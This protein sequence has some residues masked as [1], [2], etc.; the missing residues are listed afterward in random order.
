MTIA[1]QEI[2]LA[3]ARQLIDF[4][5]G[6][7]SQDFVWQE[8]LE[9]AVALHNILVHERVAYLAD[10]VGMGKTYVALGVA[11]LFR[12][13]NPGWRVLYITPRENIQRKWRKEILNFTAKNWQVTD[14]RVRSYQGTPAYGLTLCDNLLDLARQVMANPNRDFVLRMTSFSLPLSKTN[15]EQWRRKREELLDQIPWLDPAWFDL[16]G[17]EKKEQFKDNYA[18]AINVVL[19]HFD[20]VIIDEGHNLKHGLKV[21]QAVRNRL[22]AQVL[23]H[24]WFADQGFPGYG[25][26]FDRVLL[27]SAT[28][29][30]SD[31]RELWQ[32][33]NLFGYGDSW[34]ILSAT[35]SEDVTDQDKQAQT[36]RFLI[37]RLGSL[38]IGGQKQTKNLY[39]REWRNG[40]VLVHNQALPVADERQRLIVALVQKKVS[41]VL[42]SERFKNSFQIGMLASF[43]SFL[44]TAKVKS[45]ETEAV[46]TFDGAEQTEEQLEKEGVDTPSINTLA[47]SYRQEFGQALPHPKMDAIADS[48]K[49][50]FAGGEKTLI[51]VRRVKSVAEL[52]EKLNRYYDAW[53]KA[54]LLAKTGQFP[55]IQDELTKVFQ[56]YEAERLRRRSQQ[57]DL[58]M[59]PPEVNEEGAL[60]FQDEEDKGDNNNFFAWFFR[61]EGP[62]NVFSG[63]AFN[64]NRLSS[65]GSAYATF[66][67]DNYITWLLG[68]AEDPV[69]VIAEQANMPGQVVA[70][71]LREVAFAIF[72]QGSK[73]TKF[74]R[75]RVFLAYQE[76]ALFFLEHARDHELKEK[77]RIMRRE[78]F[79][80]GPVKRDSPPDNFP[81][82]L[83]ALK[84]PT[85][86]TELA[87]H[88]QLQARLW[89]KETSGDFTEQ[90]RRREQRQELLSAATR[91]GHPF[92]DLWLLTA[93]RLESISAGA[94]ERTEDRAMAL[95]KDYLDLLEQQQDQTD[96]N[97]FQEL[98]QIAT[99][100]DLILAVNFPTIRE[101]PLAQLP[102]LFGQAL[103]RQTPVGE[104]WG[105]INQSLVRQFRMPGYPLVLITT[106]VLQ[107]GEDLHTFCAKVI[108]YGISW[109]PSAMEQRTGRIDRIRSLTQRRLDN[110]SEAQPHQKLQVFYPHLRETVERLQVERVYERMNR[111]IRLMHRSFSGEQIKDSRVNVTQDFVLPPRDIE[112]ITESL[113]TVFPVKEEWLHRDWPAR[114]IESGV[115]A[116]KVLD[117]FKRMIEDLSRVFRDE[118]E[119]QRDIYSYF[120]T[121]FVLPDGQLVKPEAQTSASVRR[122]PVALFLRT[123]TGDGR[124]LLRCVSPVGVVGRE[125]DESIERINTAQRQLGFGKICAVKDTK[126]N[127]YNLTVE[128][129]IL[130][131]P[132]TTQLPEVL[133]LVSRTCHCADHMEK[134]LLARDQKMEIFREDLFGEPHRD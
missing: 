96:Y 101:E 7:P 34:K 47:S 134:A 122:Q 24:P 31:Y 59:L 37:R 25:R 20:L 12:H 111:F 108:H 115:E 57:A 65:E 120:A 110:Q 63:A 6:D 67:E 113:T 75:L 43:E 102:R 114:P 100:F 132:N 51:F 123:V 15:Q 106:D 50:N 55:A 11:G 40:G 70:Q 62:A 60:I 2:G 126:L 58:G 92:I 85:F 26:R 76:A 88:P 41:E 5:G 94:Q 9:G 23:G 71:K 97:A 13:F 128:A 21:G 64:R 77:A 98:A 103:A 119:P 118:V 45:A 1:I 93:C 74:P 42:D 56:D 95:I 121:V 69:Q 10:E 68:E 61:G 46:T 36:Q 87:K 28:P 86:F 27:L 83:E 109:T 105:G 38:T 124:V 29:L 32:Q 112:P 44:E 8:Q 80:G 84:T 133:D 72:R 73:Q 16:R 79:G 81:P 127:T 54:Y 52:A 30:E 116:L 104:M 14:N 90:L 99:N 39:R 18:R 17:Q 78:R 66:F 131:H 130:F 48:Q 53:L 22:I 3:T 117:H 89:P 129:D 82:P 4:S 19:P 107:E 125:D 35:A 49:E 33:L 91:L